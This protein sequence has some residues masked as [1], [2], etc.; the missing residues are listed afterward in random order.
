MRS[1]QLI[2]TGINNPLENNKCLFFFLSMY[3]WFL[4]EMILLQCKFGL[5]MYNAEME[6]SSVMRYDCYHSLSYK[7]DWMAQM[8]KRNFD[9][10][11]FSLVRLLFDFYRI[12]HYLLI[13]III[14]ASLTYYWSCV[15][16]GRSS[17]VNSLP[18]DH[19]YIRYTKKEKAN[20]FA[21]I[22]VAVA[23]AVAG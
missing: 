20:K 13:T 10:A 12:V 23:V 6:N 11:K 7:I 14:D 1:L 4:F 9:L 18:I 5:F 15:E 22:K 19:S 16:I 17:H 21:I 2:I 3:S 8:K